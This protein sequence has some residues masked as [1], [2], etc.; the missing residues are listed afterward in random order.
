MRGLF[1][2]LADNF[3]SVTT[4][5]KSGKFIFC[6]SF[7]HFDQQSNLIKLLHM[8][9][10]IF[11]FVQLSYN[12]SITLKLSLFDENQQLAQNT[13]PNISILTAHFCYFAIITLNTN[14]FVQ[15]LSSHDRILLINRHISLQ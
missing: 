5:T 2:W 7:L 3:V 8:L 15:L 12:A 6:A 1:S 11:L 14:S 9:Q 10:T 13:E 4:P